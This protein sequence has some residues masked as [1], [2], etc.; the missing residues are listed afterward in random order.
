MS[1]LLAHHLEWHHVPVLL[2]VFAVGAWF[3]WNLVSRLA[4][5][6]ARREAEPDR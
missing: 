4:R 5:P 2:A 6:G 1:P 3:G